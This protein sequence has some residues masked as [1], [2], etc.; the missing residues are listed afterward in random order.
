MHNHPSAQYLTPGV[1]G[2]LPTMVAPSILSLPL[3]VWMRTKP[4][5]SEGLSAWTYT[6]MCVGVV[7]HVCVHRHA[8]IRIY[9]HIYIYTYV[10]AEECT[11]VAVALAY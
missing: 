7:L 10:I 9:M 3:A 2:Y 4:E 8:C 1:G 11:R 6:C 5:E